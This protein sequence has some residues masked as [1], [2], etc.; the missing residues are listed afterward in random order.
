MAKFRNTFE[1]IVQYINGW[2]TDY[3]T[4]ERSVQHRGWRYHEGGRIVQIVTGSNNPG[5]RHML[6][7]ES[8]CECIMLSDYKG[9]LYLPDG[10]AVPKAWFYQNSDLLIDREHNLVLCADIFWSVKCD[11]NRIEYTHRDAMP[12]GPTFRIDIPDRKRAKEAQKLLAD[13]VAVATAIYKLDPKPHNG[14]SFNSA[15]EL[16]GEWS[17]QVTVAVG[18]ANAENKWWDMLVRAY[19]EVTHVPYLQIERK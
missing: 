12:R 4:H 14:V 17:E 1:S 6:A 16:L 18:R 10:E 3:D 15:D 5:N 11:T 8:G 2:E 7:V 13:R 9:K 19:T